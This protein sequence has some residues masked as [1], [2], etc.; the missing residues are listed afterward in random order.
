MFLIQKYVVVLTVSA[1]ITIIYS[2]FSRMIIILS[3]LFRVFGG[4]IQVATEEP[5]LIC[6]TSDESF[7]VK[8]RSLDDENIYL[9]FPEHL[10]KFNPTWNIINKM[11]P[12]QD[13][14]FKAYIALE[15]DLAKHYDFSGRADIEIRKKYL[16]STVTVH[17]YVLLIGIDYENTC[18]SLHGIPSKDVDCIKQQL[19][20][21]S[22]ACT[23]NL[24][25]LK[26]KDATKESILKALQTIINN[27]DERSTFIFYFSGHGGRTATRD[28]YLFTSDEQQLTASE[29]VSIIGKATTNKIIIM[30]DSCYSGGASNQFRFNPSQIQEGIHIL[31]S[32]RATEVSYQSTSDGNGFFTKYLLKGLKGEFSCKTENCAQCKTRTQN[33]QQTIIHKNT[34]TELVSYLQHAVTGQQNF[35]YTSINGSEFDVSFLD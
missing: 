33:L 12:L 31:C 18:R 19:E 28:S 7:K 4:Y 34:S 20:I 27:M 35:V 30:L 26:N 24:R 5:S 10:K 25:V 29:L 17:C 11:T 6:C 14:L 13:F 9:P 8:I 22:V 23:E 3:I 1:R 32:S 15:E 2:E 21:S 16:R